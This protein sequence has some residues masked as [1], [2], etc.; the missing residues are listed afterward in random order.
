MKG[1]TVKAILFY[2]I[3]IGITLF[4]SRFFNSSGEESKNIVSIII[5]G[6]ILYFGIAFL[7]K[8]KKGN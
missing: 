3:F 7:V 4:A 5:V 2:L 8:Y 1:D 6:T